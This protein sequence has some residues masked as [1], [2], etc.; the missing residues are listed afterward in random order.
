MHAGGRGKA[1][2]VHLV[3]SLQQAR[4]VAQRLLDSRLVTF[5]TGPQGTPVHQ[6]LVEE[7]LEVERE[8]YFSL[9]TDS[10]SRRVVAIASAAGGMEIEEVAIQNPEKVHRMAVDPVVG[11]QPFQGRRL[12]YALDLPPTV[13]RPFADLARKCYDVFMS[14]D[15]SLLEIN[16]LALAKDGRLMALDAKLNVDDDAL[17]PTHGPR[18]APRPG[19]GGLAGARGEPVRHFVCEARGRRGVHGQRSRTGHGYYGHDQSGPG[20]APPI[21]LT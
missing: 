6:V 9:T 7:T 19:A 13:V 14:N 3:S 16:P 18:L 15:C 21:S 12:A 10:A 17:F 2:G 5:Q 8:L 20:D 4:E 11:L 1:G